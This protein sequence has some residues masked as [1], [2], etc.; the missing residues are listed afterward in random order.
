MRQR[1]AL[2]EAAVRINTIVNNVVDGIVT[3]DASGAIESINHSAEQMFGYTANEVLG[4]P[5]IVLLQECCQDSYLKELRSSNADHVIPSLL[6]ADCDGL[7]KRQDGSTFSIELAISQVMVK[8]QR[9]LIHIV[10]DVTERKLANQKQ[11]L[12]ASVFENA[13]EGIVITDVDGTIQSVN[14]AYTT[15]TQLSEE[16]LVGKNP[17]MLQS[18]KHD[19]EFYEQMWAS[20]S[21]AGHWQGEI[22]NRR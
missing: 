21:T 13:T 3:V 1:E 12:A 10:R 17:R 19:R 20:I 14:P 15:I 16:E 2:R 4:K 6:S 8:G 5:F 11:R 22:W 18:G 9:L 7:G